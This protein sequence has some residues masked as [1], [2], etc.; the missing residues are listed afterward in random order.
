MDKIFEPYFTTKEKGKGT[1]LGL[2]VAYGII[3]E[4]RGNIKIDTEIGKGT[5]FT[6]YLPLM[7]KSDGAKSIDTAEKWVGGNERILLVDDDESVVTLEEQVLE[8][9]GYKVTSRLH[10]I[11][12]LETFKASPQVFDMVVTDMSMPKMTGIQLSKALLS[13]RPDI[14]III[15][16]GFSEHLTEEN[17]DSYGLKGMLMK[18][19][20]G[21]KMAQMVRKVL[22]EAKA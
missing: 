22:D 20:V 12:A 1:G 15:C 10:S 19:I 11:E 4:H 7:E 17:L 6:A 5:T 9:M 13:I 16:T 18:P 14:P 8:R 3:R 2:A 21:R